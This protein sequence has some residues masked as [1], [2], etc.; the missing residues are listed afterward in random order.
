M[1]FPWRQ[2]GRNQDLP[3][4]C[5][6]VLLRWDSLTASDI[7][8][9]TSISPGISKTLQNTN[10]MI[11]PRNNRKSRHF[12]AKLWA[13]LEERHPLKGCREVRGADIPNIMCVHFLLTSC[14]MKDSLVVSIFQLTHIP[15][16]LGILVL[17]T[18][19]HLI[20]LFKACSCLVGSMRTTSGIW[21]VG[22]PITFW[23]YLHW[24][25]VVSLCCHPETTEY[26]KQ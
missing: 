11:N 4:S 14:N 10:F 9:H 5:S 24:M 20:S 6:R 1:L 21:L 25:F 15:D 23:C 17:M 22:K 3:A 18:T 16:Q 26:R 8:A 13:A 19:L 7:N 12:S 2:I